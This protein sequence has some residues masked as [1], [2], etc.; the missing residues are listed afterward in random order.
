MLS[1]Y[2]KKKSSYGIASYGKKKS[3]YGIASYDILPTVRRN[4]LTVRR[5]YLL[6]ALLLTTFFLR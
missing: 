2:G 1:S 6:T 3:S 4:F 5:K